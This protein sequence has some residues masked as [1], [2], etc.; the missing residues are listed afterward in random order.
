MEIYISFNYSINTKE[1]RKGS[2]R[3][4][5]NIGQ[6]ENKH[7]DER[8]KPNHI[9]NNIKCKWSKDPNQIGKK[10]RTNYILATLNTI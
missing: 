6:I 1:G 5:V 10:A 3:N 2:E 8:T 7:Y 4:N 9:N